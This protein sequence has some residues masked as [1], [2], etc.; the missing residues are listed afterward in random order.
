MMQQNPVEFYN[1]GKL[2]II[3]MKGCEDIAKKIDMHLKKFNENSMPNIESFLIP[4]NCPRFGTGEAKAV[5]SHSVRTY[6]IYK[7]GRAHV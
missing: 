7:I 2:G 1:L 3:G 5:I 4:T 6:D